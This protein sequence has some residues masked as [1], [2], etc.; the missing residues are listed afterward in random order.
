MRRPRVS[1]VDRLKECVVNAHMKAFAAATGRPMSAKLADAQLA[2]HPVTE[3]TRAE[4][5]AFAAHGP[6]ARQRG[7]AMRGWRLDATGPTSSAS[8]RPGRTLWV[9]RWTF[10]KL[11][12]PMQRTFADDL[13]WAAAVLVGVLI[14]FLVF[15]HDDAW[16]LIGSFIGVTITIVGLNVARRVSR[17]LKR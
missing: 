8:H 3:V 13:K 9:M 4:A 15:G 5:E 11:P 14:A 6:E 10:A 1:P 12:R 16:L 17:H 2:D 7:C